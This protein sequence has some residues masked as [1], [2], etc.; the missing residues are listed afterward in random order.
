MVHPARWMLR[1][2]TTPVLLHNTSCASQSR[3]TRQNLRE[4]PRM[5]TMGGRWF[6]DLDVSQPASL[7]R[8]DSMPT[9]ATPLAER[10]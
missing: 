9:T 2:T 8:R 4:M 10:L 7:V 3:L 1:A 6:F 5:D